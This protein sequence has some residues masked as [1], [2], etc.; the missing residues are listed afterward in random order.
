MSVW[1][2][3]LHNLL[4]FDLVIVLVALGNAVCFAAT[5]RAA[6]ALYRRAV[7]AEKEN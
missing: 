1:Q 3:I 4:G 5:R 2:V 6:N 7:D